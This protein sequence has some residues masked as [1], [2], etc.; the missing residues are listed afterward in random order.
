MVSNFALTTGRSLGDAILASA[1]LRVGLHPKLTL[2]G[3]NTAERCLVVLG[4]VDHT[5]LFPPFVGQGPRS[6]RYMSDLQS[7]A[8]LADRTSI[9]A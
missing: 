2:V 6:M 4:R 3:S 9:F 7:H 1:S 5:R 8:S